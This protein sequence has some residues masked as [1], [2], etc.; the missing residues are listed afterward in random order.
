MRMRDS[1]LLRTGL[2]SFIL[3][4]RDGHKLSMLFCFYF[5]FA[6][7]FLVLL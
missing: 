6:D 7:M 3:R 5:E 4:G 2:C 1:P